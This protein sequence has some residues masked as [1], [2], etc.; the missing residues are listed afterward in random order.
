MTFTL[1]MQDPASGSRTLL[2][3]LLEASAHTQRGAGVFSFASPGGV[4]LLLGDPDFGRFLQRGQFD[5]I[6]GVDAVTVPGSLTALGN[7]QA[8]Y[9]GLMVSAFCHERRG[10]LFHPK[11]CWFANDDNGQILVGSGNLTRGGLLKNWEAFADVS[12]E[13]DSLHAMLN[14]WSEWRTSN[15][16]ALRPVDDAVAVQCARRN[17]RERRERHEEEAVE[18]VDVNVGNASPGAEML[19]AEIPRAADRWNQANFD[20][21][22]FRNFFQLEPDSF[23]RVLLWP[24][25]AAGRVGDTP[26]VRKGVSVKSRN[27]RIEL[28]QAAGREYPETGR[29]IAAFLRVAPRSFRYRL[30]MT[31]DPGYASVAEWLDR[32]WARRGGRADRRQ[33]I[34][35]TFSE[36]TAA[37][38]E[39]PI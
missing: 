32:E 6:V 3:A 36:F 4:Q 37:A 12:L 18:E 15:A 2:E 7:A 27:F 14:A 25:D 9:P 5:L 38:P 31:G 34:T 33:R 29:P 20:L 35:T 1:R 28:G 30:I 26:E 16:A 17:E 39:I 23:Q 21:A 24:V 11:L 10:A 8:Q 13:Q 22:T 19:I